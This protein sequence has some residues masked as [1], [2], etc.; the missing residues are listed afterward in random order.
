MT[1]DAGDRPGRDLAIVI[2]ST[3]PHASGGR[4]TWLAHLLP[5]LIEA[6]IRPTVYACPPPAG[7][8]QVHSVP[9]G[10]RLRRVRTAGTG[11]PSVRRALLNAPVA[12]DIGM[13][14]RRARALL[15]RDGFGGGVV[16]ALGAVIEVS[17]GLKLRKRYRD[18][19]VACAVHGHVARE[20]GHSLPWAKPFLGRVERRG[21]QACDAVIANGRDT[22]EWLAGSMGVSSTVVPNG[23]D[24]ARFAS[25]QPPI[26]QLLRDA[27]ERGEAVLSMVATLRD[28]KGI[29]PLIAAL[30]ALERL[31]GPRFLVVFVGKGDQ[32][33]YRNYAE[34]LGVAAHVSFAGEQSD[35]L[36]WLRGSDISVALSGGTG[37]AIA[38]IEAMAAGAPVVAWDSAIY[39]QLI[40]PGETGVLVPDGDVDALAEALARVLGDNAARARLGRAGA[41][42]AE[43]FDWSAAGASLVEVLE[44]L[45][46]VDPAR[47]RSLA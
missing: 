34:Q 16:L 7:A 32:G 41:L 42:A 25:A 26:P 38:A 23:V 2:Y 40:E 22:K 9:A 39:R 13:F 18:T 4:E 8:R 33:R 5:A 15:E 24:V 3:F 43:R 11:P 19:R 36:P 1:G 20:L 45:F 30:P 46:R 44:P 37:M 12:W 29:R 47:Q 17:A 6:G 28:I 27:H 31:H 10:V 21:L 35:V 14:V